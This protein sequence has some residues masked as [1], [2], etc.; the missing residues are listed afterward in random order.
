MDV[1]YHNNLLNC[2]NVQ[3]S[4]ASFFATSTDITNIDHD[5][6]R[7][8]ML[9]YLLV[10]EAHDTLLFIVGTPLYLKMSLWTIF[11]YPSE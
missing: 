1:H 7:I 10:C 2:N 11:T 6:R 8:M 4:S 9:L 5:S 3:R